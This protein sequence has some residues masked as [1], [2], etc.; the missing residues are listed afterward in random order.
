[1]VGLE[2]EGGGQTLGLH[3]FTLRAD[4]LDR[5]SLACCSPWGFRVGHD[6][7][8]EQ[9]Q[10]RSPAESDGSLCDLCDLVCC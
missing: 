2:L 10:S 8:M 4:I 6:R 7:E 3:C 1:M 9:Q 5:A